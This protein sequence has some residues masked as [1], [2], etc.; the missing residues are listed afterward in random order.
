LI[1]STREHLRGQIAVTFALASVALFAMVALAVDGARVLVEQRGLQNG[2]DGAALTGAL[3]LGPGAAAPQSATAIDDTVYA[4][5]R[6]LGIDFSNNYGAAGHLLTSGPCAPNACV[7]GSTPS[8][9]YNPSNAATSPCCNGWVDRSGAY[10]LTITTPY[11]YKNSGGDEAFVYVK[12]THQLPLVFSSSLYPTIGIS[13]TS[14]A[15][16][17]AIPYAIFAFKHNDSAD[18]YL[19]GNTSLLA[20]KRVGD[21]G[22]LSSTRTG[23]LNFVCN[24]AYGGQYGGDLWEYTNTSSTSINAASVSEGKCPGPS[25]S[26]DNALGYYEY[27]PNVNLPPDP[28]ATALQSGSVAN[29]ATAMLIPTRS[30]DPTQPLGP[31]YSNIQVNGTLVLQPGVYFFEGTTSPAGLNIQAGGT[32]ET[33]DCYLQTLPNCNKTTAKTNACGGTGVGGVPNNSVPITPVVSWPGITNN[34]H[35][36]SDFDFGVLLVFWPAGA[37]VNASSC[38]NQNPA[39]S[40]NYFCTLNPPSSGSVNTMA[41]AGGANIYL[42][43]TSKFHSVSLFVDPNHAGD[44]WNFTTQSSMSGSGCSSQICAKQIG[45]GSNVIS[46]QGGGSISINGA[47]LAPN[48]N[49]SLAGSPSGYG[50]GQV[51]AYT[52]T[53]KGTTAVVENYNPLALAYVPVLVQ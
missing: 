38:T 51:L 29:G 37:D 1:T 10:T 23:S 7:S 25:P 47:M 39:L 45:L 52:I 8:G 3:D 6:T 9:P 4:L 28:T 44:G 48:D 53:I 46:I 27:P 22:S 11:N 15:R 40:G 26:L 36:T 14:I 5:E 13:V 18:I 24:A 42:T 50:Y 16:N 19:N 2:A 21:N 31:R 30:L 12:L 17:H 41:L 43:S 33:G 49:V 32:V 34:F 35:C 20:N